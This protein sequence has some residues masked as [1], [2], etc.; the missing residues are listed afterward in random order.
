MKFSGW[1]P[2]SEF[3]S[4]APESGESSE[5]ESEVLKSGAML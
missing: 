5:I 2:S 4:E 1:E 3:G